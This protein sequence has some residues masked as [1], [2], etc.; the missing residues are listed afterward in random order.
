MLNWQFHKIM[1]VVK[2]IDWKC[3]FKN[4]K[5]GNAILSLTKRKKN[6]MQTNFLHD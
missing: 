4:R 2:E 5:V 3:R 6:S 1:C